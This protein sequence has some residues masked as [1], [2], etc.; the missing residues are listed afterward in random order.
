MARIVFHPEQ[1]HTVVEHAS[2]LRHLLP[3]TDRPRTP[4]AV[5]AVGGQRLVQLVRRLKSPFPS[6]LQAIEPLRLALLGERPIPWERGLGALHTAERALAI[7]AIVLSDEVRRIDYG[8]SV[9]AL[10][11]DAPMYQHGADPLACAVV[12]ASGL[13]AMRRCVAGNE[14]DVLSEI[15]RAVQDVLQ[16][17]AALFSRLTFSQRMDLQ[18]IAMATVGGDA[19]IPLSEVLP[20]LTAVGAL[21]DH[22]AMAPTVVDAA[23][24]DLSATLFDMPFAAA[25]AAALRAFRE[26]YV[27]ALMDR[28]GGNVSQAAREA[29]LDRSNWRRLMLRDRGALSPRD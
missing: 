15:E 9:P 6:C 5:V 10:Y 16:Q 29:G 26:R 3:Q 11:L 7:G 8:R 27:E 1:A 19:M 25:Q 13:G 21:L 4:V 23:A 20:T 24:L 17:G 28:C 12:V 22:S 14:Y 2:A 18:R